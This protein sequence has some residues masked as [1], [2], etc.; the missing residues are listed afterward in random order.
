[1]NRPSSAPI[2]TMHRYSHMQYHA[3]PFTAEL[4]RCQRSDYQLR[5]T[6][7]YLVSI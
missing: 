4:L 3:V 1:M 6:V 7:R 5:L 2:G